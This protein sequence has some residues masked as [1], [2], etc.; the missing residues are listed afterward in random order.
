MRS[1][2]SISG[3]TPEITRETRVLQ[4]H[5]IHFGKSVRTSG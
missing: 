4:Q 3:E 2:E 1:A 5:L